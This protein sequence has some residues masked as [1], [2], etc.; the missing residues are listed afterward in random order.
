ML[1]CA[2]AVGNSVGSNDNLSNFN[3]S[4]VPLISLILVPPTK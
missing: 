4:C 3:I 2:N 1:N